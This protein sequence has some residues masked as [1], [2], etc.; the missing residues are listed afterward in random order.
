[1]G[2]RRINQVA[3]GFLNAAVFSAQ[4]WE[5]IACILSLSPR[6]LQ[7]VLGIFNDHTESAI[8]FHLGVSSHTVHTH[9][10]RL[11]AKL[12][13]HTRA[14]LVLRVMAEGLPEM[15]SRQRRANSICKV[16]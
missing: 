1:M 10:N 8:A 11:Y 9:L 15:K 16:L 5:N 12:A 13:V 4:E 14:G 6:Q 7:I 2:G 3:Q